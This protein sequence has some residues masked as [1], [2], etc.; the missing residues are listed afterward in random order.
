MQ[1][2]NFT[3]GIEEEFQLIDRKSNEL[4]SGFNALI[5]KGNAV[6]G[7][8]IKSEIVQSMLELSSEVCSDISVIRDK[9]YRERAILA[10]IAHEADLALLS[11]GTHPFSSWRHQQLTVKSRYLAIEE[12]LQDI[13]RSR[14]IFGLHVHVGV[15]QR[16][17]ALTSMNQVRTWLP[18]LL[19]LSTNSPFW[20]GYFTGIKSYRSVVWQAGFRNGVPDA[21]PSLQAFDQYINDL[22]I[23]SYIASSRDIW[24][25]IRLHPTFSTLEFRIFDMP[26]TLEDT[27]ALTALCQ[28][29]V[30]KLAW[31][32]SHQHTVPVLPREY[33]AE[34][35][36]RALR[37]GLDAT[38]FDFVKGHTI[39]IRDSTHELFDFIDDVLDDLGCRREITYLR[40]LLNNPWGTGA[41]RQIALYQQSGSLQQVVDFLLQRTLLGVDL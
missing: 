22:T 17:L 35:K 41:D 37:Y 24:W 15:A 29:L 9:L 11:A 40:T 5:E 18:H 13:V 10:R 14:V 25:D 16:E 19:A 39:S 21:F 36:W 31:L 34:N 32:Y 20:E 30:A 33:I 7:E 8:R 1:A 26:S 27:L 6:F 23:A 4:S 28:A 2:L 38:I 12:E 3:L